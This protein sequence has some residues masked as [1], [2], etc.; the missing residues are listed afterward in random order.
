LNDSS[1]S[2]GSSPSASRFVRILDSLESETYHDSRG[3]PW[4]ILRAGLKARNQV[5]QLDQPHPHQG[6]HFG[7]NAP[8]EGQRERR[9][10]SAI[11]GYVAAA[12][13]VG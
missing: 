3:D 8:T 10:G 6:S 2:M 7:I 4:L 1:S 11:N 5:V 13:S 9:V 12:E